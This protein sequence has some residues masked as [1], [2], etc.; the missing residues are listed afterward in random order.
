MK[1][2]TSNAFDEMLARARQPQVGARLAVVDPIG[3]AMN[4]AQNKLAQQ[5]RTAPSPIPQ[6]NAPSTPVVK[7]MP[8]YGPA[9]S[10]AGS[11]V[12]LTPLME[13]M[14]AVLAEIRMQG[15]LQK[16]ALR[17]QQMS[18]RMDWVRD[19]GDADLAPSA[20]QLPISSTP[21]S[22]GGG[23][24][25]AY[26]GNTYIAWFVNT[27]NY[28]IGVQVQA[29]VWNTPGGT[30]FF[31]KT[32][33]DSGFVGALSNGGPAGPSDHTGIIRLAA[34]E[35]LFARNF[36]A[37]VVLTNSDVFLTQIFDHKQYLDDQAFRYEPYAGA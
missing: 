21:I 37:A 31:S 6:P 5:A 22:T 3:A 26:T 25:A 8:A 9:P 34:G 27:R 28:P 19:V 36:D 29:L 30:L 17:M 16:R 11:S 24:G 13:I 2:P 18:M 1:G 23:G 12:D 10:G 7:F 35:T 33:T 20:N 14:S 15:A 32:T 4:L